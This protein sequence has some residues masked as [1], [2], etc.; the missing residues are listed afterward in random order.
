MSHAGHALRHS[1][2]LKLVMKSSAGVLSSS[3][4]VEQWMGV[5][6]R[7]NSR[8]KSFENKRIVVSSTE[9]IGY[10]MSVI[11]VQNSTEIE[12]VYCNSFVPFELS[13][14]GQLFLIWFLYIE[15]AV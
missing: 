10:D 3:V 2:Q 9:H 6:V 11:K 12:L 8:I 15:L 1:S 4:A 5:R 14:I 7:L 13:Y